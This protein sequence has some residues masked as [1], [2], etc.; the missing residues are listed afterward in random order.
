[1][2]GGEPSRRHALRLILGGALTTLARPIAAS[3]SDAGATD[4]LV[5]ELAELTPGTV[6]AAS[7]HGMPILVL[8][9]AGKIEALSAICT[10]EGCV[11]VWEAERKLI[12][13]PCHSGVFDQ[14]GE[15]VGGPPPAPLI[16]LPVRVDGG[17]V[18]VI[19]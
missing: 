14:L 1:M 15:V 2:T 16:Q 18:Y 13:C 6:K 12:L 4:V 11:V 9:V 8:N 5:A 19:D 10:H 7:F 3:D 17:K